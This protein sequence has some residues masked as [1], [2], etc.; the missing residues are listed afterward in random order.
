MRRCRVTTALLINVSL[1]KLIIKC[2]KSKNNSAKKSEF[3]G[4]MFVGLN[5]CANFAVINVKD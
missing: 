2:L 5:N 1:A 3:N 4:L